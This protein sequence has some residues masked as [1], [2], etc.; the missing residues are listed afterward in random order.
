VNR[1][2]ITV[3]QILR[4][5]R[6]A[7]GATGWRTAP[8]A[9][10]YTQFT[11][12]ELQTARSEV[13]EALQAENATDEDATRADAIATEI[14]RRNTVTTA[15]NERRRRLADTTVVERWRQDTGNTQAQRRG[16]H[17][18]DPP[19]PTGDHIVPTD[20]R[21]QLA[22]GAA[23]YRDRGMTGTSEILRLPNATDLRALVTTVTLPHQPQRLPGIVHP[24]DQVLKVADL[25]DQQT[26]TSGS[27][28]WVV[29]TSTAP[30]AAEVAEGL[31]KPE[32]AMT[33]TV[34]SAALA[35]IAVWIPL[36]RQSA[37]DDA[38]L[39]GYIQGRLSFAVEKRI[40]TQVLN[41]NGT[42]PNMRGILNTVGIQEQDSDLGMLIA[43]RK[44]I[45]KTQVSGYNPSGVVMH[46]VDWEGVELTQ[47]STTGTFLFTKDPSSLA[48][49]RI[50]GLPVVPTVGIAAGTALVGAFK[51][52]ATLWRKPGV[53]I[54]MSDSHVD[55]FI[56]NILILLAET[57]AQLAVYAPAAF[58]KVYNVP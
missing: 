16:Q 24:P 19:P 7:F 58:V 11:D 10:D 55:N 13:L 22:T 9:V 34:A 30:P 36:T 1:R 28:E 48:A 3:A 38:Q 29:E 31:A 17:Q 52:G 46:P 49:P 4:A 57:R 8:T 18:D 43:I 6:R 12:A 44:A 47:D 37:E 26:A 42:A 25:V 2:P 15:T 33:F 53:R 56:K 41:G 51:E 23:G 54:L 27:V 45:T 5:R 21:D 39:T 32:A 35:T 14:E 50:W 40:D 20:W